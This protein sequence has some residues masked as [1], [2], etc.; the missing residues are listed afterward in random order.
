MR[1]IG[2]LQV[3]VLVVDNE[4]NPTQLSS[5]QQAF[6]TVRWVVNKANEGFAKANNQALAISAGALVLFL[7]PDTLVSENAFTSCLKLKGYSLPTISFSVFSES[8]ANTGDI[9]IKTRYL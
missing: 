6:P 7:N 5:L 9:I 2:A 8:N 4:S 3:E 1:A